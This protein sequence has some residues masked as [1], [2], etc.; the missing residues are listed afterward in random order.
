MSDT[1]RLNITFEPGFDPRPNWMRRLETAIAD[2]KTD[3]WALAGHITFHGEPFVDHTGPQYSAWGVCPD[4]CDN[5]FQ[6]NGNAPCLS[7][8]VDHP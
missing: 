6:G 4:G 8:G 1:E 3:G 5:D 7:K 2:A